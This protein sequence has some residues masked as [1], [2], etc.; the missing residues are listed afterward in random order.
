MSLMHSGKERSARTGIS[1]GVTAPEYLPVLNL[2]QSA[3]KHMQTRGTK[4]SQPRNN[5][6]KQ[7]FTQDSG[8][9]TLRAELANVRGRDLDFAKTLKKR[10]HATIAHEGVHVA[11][12]I[13]ELPVRQQNETPAST[14]A[15]VKETDEAE[16]DARC[17][18]RAHRS[19]TTACRYRASWA[20]KALATTS[21]IS[22]LEMYI[23]PLET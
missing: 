23:L 19:R 12:A 21:T 2:R 20:R 8:G 3:R 11:R 5:A 14:D 15:P 4:R 17:T 16:D 7:I 18:D 10:A 13:S 22:R 1:S 9:V 6:M